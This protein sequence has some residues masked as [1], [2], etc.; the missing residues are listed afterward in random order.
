MHS[1]ETARR[2]ARVEPEAAT[3]PDIRVGFV[4]SPA[5]TLLP[6]AGFVD[7]LRHAADEGDR[8]RQIHCRWEILG[9]S[10]E[11]VRSSCGAEVTPWR[12]YG[13]PGGE[14]GAFDYIVVVGGLTSAFGQHAPETFDYLRLAAARQVSVVG[15][16]TGS[17]A[18]AEAGLLEGRRCAV[19]VRHREEFMARYP[20][21]T[22]TTQ[23]LY[24][25]DGDR[26]TCP[27]GT[28]AIDVAVELVMRHAGKARALKGLTEM[29]VDEHRIAMHQPRT[30]HDDLHDCGDWRVEQAVRVMQGS[31][32]AP[33]SSQRLAQRVG[34]SVSQL[35]RAFRQCC[36]TTATE[37][38]REMRLLRAKWL[39]LNT[40]RTV[41]RV[42]QECGFADASHLYRWFM[43][44]FNEGPRSF[45]KSRKVS[46]AT[47]GLRD[48]RR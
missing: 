3:T 23:E 32:S 10:P 43:H 7:T 29:A 33:L 20:G 11:P 44:A 28:A 31:L 34:I 22:V 13:D 46:P 12:S 40:D 4:L 36:G 14:P 45:R 19:H 27:G 2:E 18:M 9:A 8:S 39:L 17:F 24:V 1:S 21:V 5:F 38:W 30:A 48:G 25:V 35:D 42:A 47:V 26:I 15:L 6:F 16:C 41:A 37:V